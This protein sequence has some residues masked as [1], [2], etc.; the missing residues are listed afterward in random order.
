LELALEDIK[1]AE[2][3]SRSIDTGKMIKM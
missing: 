2:S 3:I 1:V